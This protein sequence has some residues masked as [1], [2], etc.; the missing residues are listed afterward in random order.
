MGDLSNYVIEGVLKKYQG[1]GGDVVLPAGVTSIGEEA[2]SDCESLTSVTIPE[3]VTRIGLNAFKRCVSLT[4]VTIPASVT[5]I[6]QWAFYGCTSLTEIAVDPANEMYCSVDGVLYNKEQTELIC[7]PG[8]KT[9]TFSIPAGVTIIG[10]DAFS[11]C[12][13]LT[14]VAIPDGVTTIGWLAFSKCERLISV[15]IPESVTSID[16]DAF[17]DCESLTIHAPS[18]SYAEEYARKNGIPFSA[19]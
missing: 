8:G 16:N 9:G 13:S 3:G 17:S 15:M 5:R 7:C 12:C 18:G 11:S 14:S 4:N 2:F 6:G 1:L 19:V 10:D